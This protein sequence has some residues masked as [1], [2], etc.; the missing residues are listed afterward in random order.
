MPSDD[1][2]RVLIE[3]FEVLVGRFRL[4]K[5]DGASPFDAYMLDESAA[6]A[7]PSEKLAIQFL[8]SV[9]N[10]HEEWSCGPFDHREAAKI[11]LPRD[12]E[13]YAR[14]IMNPFFLS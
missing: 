13:A 11:W 7:S 9:L 1:E 10:P 3:R 2:M 14:W 6:S 4:E 5:L 8:L 12:L